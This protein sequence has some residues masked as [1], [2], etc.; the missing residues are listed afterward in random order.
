MKP[1]TTG[2]ALFIASVAAGLLVLATY[3]A[4]APQPEPVHVAIAGFEQFL[5]SVSDVR[6]G[7]LARKLAGFELTE[8]ATSARL[9]EWQKRFTGKHTRLVLTALADL[10]AFENLPAADLPTAPPPDVATQRAIFARVVDYVAA[11]WPRLPNFSATRNTSRFEIAT[12]EEIDAEERQA[13]RFRL[14]GETLR[15]DALGKIRSGRG[16]GQWLYFAATSSMPVTYRDGHEVSGKSGKDE[17]SEGSLFRPQLSTV[18]EFGPILAVVVGDALHGQVLWSH[19]ESNEGKPVA[20][21]R[22]SVPAAASHYAV[23]TSPNKA[24]LSPAY[25]GEIAADAASGAILRL[26][27]IADAG[28]ESFSSTGIV[29]EYGPV[30]IAGKTYI[31]PIHSIAISRGPVSRNDGSVA[32]PEDEPRTNVNDVRFTNYHIFRSEM[33]ILPDAGPQ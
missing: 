14:P 26:T 23:R 22:Y 4:R 18:G 10:S 8:R 15:Y 13:D 11:I 9:A 2:P 24:L 6:D 28:N 33:R 12:M 7:D 32:V 3:A 16:G 27:L 19:W 21:F 20:V 30:T 17:D 29:V 1:A 5:A 25:R 31:C